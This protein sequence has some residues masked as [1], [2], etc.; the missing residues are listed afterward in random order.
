MCGISRPAEIADMAELVV[1]EKVELVMGILRVAS[2]EQI[3]KI[4]ESMELTED[5]ALE[6]LPDGKRRRRMLLQIEDAM[7]DVEVSER[8]ETIRNNLFPHLSAKVVEN[9]E[10]RF[11]MKSELVKTAEESKPALTESAREN[12]ERVED[13]AERIAETIS[14]LKHMGLDSLNKTLRR[15]LKLTGTIGGEKDSLNWLSILSQINEARPNYTE[16]EIIAAIKRAAVASSPIR[17]YLE[18]RSGNSLKDTM[19]FIRQYLKEKDPS[20]LLQELGGSFQQEEEEATKFLTRL[21]AMRE[22][23]TLMAREDGKIS[24]EHIYSTYVRAVV[25]GLNNAT[26]RYRIEALLRARVDDA[27]VIKE[28]NSVTSEEVERRTKKFSAKAA[29]V[30]AASAQ[31]EKS[32]DMLVLTENM[33]ALAEQVQAIQKE[34]ATNKQKTWR[35]AYKRQPIHGC[36]ACKQKGE[37]YCR[38]CWVC[39]D[40]NHKSWECPTKNGNTSSSGPSSST[41]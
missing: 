17:T 20:D 1:N 16:N 26:V 2:F 29:R 8:I 41:N 13:K 12:N 36:S 15:E 23:L 11:D 28:I 32:P 14:I 22:K 6:A 4:F 35:P 18:A 3:Q 33:K 5:P 34:L 10:K 25:T 19:K 31:V 39:G 30:T 38:H 21:I 37:L 40:D 7:E 24:E 9:L 27:D